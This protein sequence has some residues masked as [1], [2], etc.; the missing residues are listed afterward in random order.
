MIETTFCC[1]QAQLRD[2]VT[3]SIVDFNEK[4]KVIE[5]RQPI[6]FCCKV[7]ARREGGVKKGLFLRQKILKHVCMLMGL[8]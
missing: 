8:T 7:A 4:L 2:L 1:P 6:V 3:G 5:W